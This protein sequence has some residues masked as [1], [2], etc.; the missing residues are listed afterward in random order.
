MKDSRF[1]IQDSRMKTSMGLSMVEIVVAAAILITIVTAAGTAWQ[2]Y[3]KT[4]ASSVRQS[5]AAL[6][7][8][9]T[10]E[11]LRLFRDQSWTNLI[12]PLTTGVDY[13]LFSS[14]TLYS[15]TTSQITI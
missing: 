7:V 11:V 10:S 12:A 4:A 3:L 2:L 15:A 9:E 8:E 13:Q 14:G 1:R 5:Q 6:I